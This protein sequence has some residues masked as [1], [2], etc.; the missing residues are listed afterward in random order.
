MNYNEQITALTEAVKHFGVAIDLAALREVNAARIAQ[1]AEHQNLVAE[2]EAQIAALHAKVAASTS[3]QRAVRDM[4]ESRLDNAARVVAN[5]IGMQSPINRL[6]SGYHRGNEIDVVTVAIG[7]VHVIVSSSTGDFGRE[8][9]AHGTV[10]RYI[11]TAA[12]WADAYNGIV[13]LHRRTEATPTTTEEVE[14]ANIVLALFGD[15]Q[16]TRADSDVS[17]F[18]DE[19]EAGC[20]NE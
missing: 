1:D 3:A 15:S 6:W 14:R 17:F 8:T 13:K 4:L 2:V 7:G 9:V 5:R 20:S 18:D 19:E 16:I 10:R 11:R 12:V